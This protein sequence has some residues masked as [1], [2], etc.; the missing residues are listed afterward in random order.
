MFTG[1]WWVPGGQMLILAG[2]LLS[3]TAPGGSLGPVPEQSQTPEQ[4]RIPQRL[5]FVGGSFDGY[6]D[7]ALG[8]RVHQHRGANDYM[9]GYRAG[10][11]AYAAYG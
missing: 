4:R 6:A 7:A 10:Q 5:H 3:A 9:A 11:E 8:A 2:L 1:T